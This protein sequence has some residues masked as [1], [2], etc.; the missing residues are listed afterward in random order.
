MPTSTRPTPGS[1][2]ALAAALL[3]AA[4]ATLA[5]GPQG[6]RTIGALGPHLASLMDLALDSKAAASALPSIAPHDH[7]SEEEAE[8]ALV[9]KL[10]AMAGLDD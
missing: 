3:L 6:H 9:A 7:L 10:D 2:A 1:A 8:A 4:Q 5:W